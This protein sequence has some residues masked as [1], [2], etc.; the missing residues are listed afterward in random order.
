VSDAVMDENDGVGT[1]SAFFVVEL[2][3]LNVYKC[4]GYGLQRQQGRFAAKLG[5]Q[6][7]QTQAEC[8]Q[9]DQGA[10]KWSL[11]LPPVRVGEY[12]PCRDRLASGG[13]A[14]GEVNN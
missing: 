6:D 7:V 1:S 5:A 12:N 8:W 13:V 3:A 4:P 2:P 11:A 14:G 10:G 9:N